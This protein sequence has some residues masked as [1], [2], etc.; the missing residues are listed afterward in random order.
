MSDGLTKAG[1][2]ISMGLATFKNDVKDVDSLI[3]FADKALYSAKE[4]GRNR[5]ECYKK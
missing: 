3:A 2:T 5:V 4:N 1:V